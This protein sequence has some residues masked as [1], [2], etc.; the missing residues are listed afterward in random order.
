MTATNG[1]MELTA[2]E[3]ASFVDDYSAQPGEEFKKL[4]PDDLTEKWEVFGLVDAYEEREP[5]QYIVDG[6]IPYPSLIAVYG[7]PGSLKSMMMADLCAAIA[8]GQQWLPPASGELAKP[9]ATFAVEQNP[10]LWIDFDNGKRRTHERMDA[11][12]RARGLP[13]DAPFHYV[14]MPRPWLDISRPDFTDSLARTINKLKA[15][16]VMIDNLGL[17]TGDT[18]ENNAEMAQVMANLRYL[19]EDTESCIGVIHHQRKSSGAGDKGIRKGETLRGH[20]S[21]EAALDLAILVERAQG[22][23]EVTA[24]LTKVRGFSEHLAFG[25]RFTYEHR[26][27]THDLA[28]AKFFSLTI[29]RQEDLERMEI[30]SIIIRQIDKE[31]G[32]KQAELIKA[33]KAELATNHSNIK[34]TV[35]LL[36]GLITK[37]AESGEIRIEKGARNATQHYV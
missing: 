7:G 35:D 28:L 14:S 33:V 22:A 12:A 34:A 31:Q 6:L 32:I 20:S 4:E 9:G 30:E 11:V 17:V 19:C 13:V 25:A 5:W 2:E 27:N 16:F 18:E 15:K 21:I 24:M 3:I 36:R 8:G 29:D 23:D 1:V 10:I 37:L 26:A